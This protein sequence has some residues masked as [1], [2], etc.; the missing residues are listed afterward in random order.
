M[1][2]WRWAKALAGGGVA[3]LVPAIKGPEHASLPPQVV[4]RVR[5]LDRH[6]AG[7]AAIA[8]AAGVSESSV[9]TRA[10]G[11]AARGRR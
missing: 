1:C 11:P 5:E 10:P 9:R 2:V 7:K 8:A 6:G 3:G 4:E